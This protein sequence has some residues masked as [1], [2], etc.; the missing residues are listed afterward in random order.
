MAHILVIDDD[1]YM[2]KVIQQMLERKGH[3][4]VVEE[5]GVKGVRRYQK[6]SFDL[7]I[8]DIVMPEKEGLETIQELKQVAPGVKIIAVS[9][10]ALKGPPKGYLALAKQFG[11]METIEKPFSWKQLIETVNHVLET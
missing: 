8:T 2:R 3:T 9:G 11:A 5:D 10:G 1:M 7:V 4:V 6:E